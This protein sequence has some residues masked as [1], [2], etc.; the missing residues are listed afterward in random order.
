MT[1]RTLLR[2][3]RLFRVFLLE[4][5]QPERFYSAL[6]N[7]SLDALQEHLRLAGARVL[8][9]GAGPSEFAAA[10]RRAGARYVPLDADPAVASVQD[11][12]IVADAGRLPFGDGTFDVVFS[13]NLWEHVRTPELVA[14][15]LLRVVAPGGVLYL[16]YTNWLS[17]WGGHETSPW[18]WLGA[19]RAAQRYQR[20]TGHRPKN[21][22]DENMF[23]VSVSQGLAW[24]HGVD[25]SGHGEVVALRPRYWPD[26]A[27]AVLRLPG[28][29]EIVTWNLLVIV[30]KR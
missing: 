6:A 14:D 3:V 30:R 5:S 23:R 22:I 11:G 13:S 7:D 27:S 18:H 15:E 8:D 28:L 29:R 24:A 10:F 16:A 9:A 17:P 21:R 20:R 26:W 2:S 1:R 4:Q 12:G 25:R 19:R